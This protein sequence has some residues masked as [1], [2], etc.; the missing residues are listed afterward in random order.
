MKI[1]FFLF[2]SSYHV[3]TLLQC[4]LYTFIQ[5]TMTTVSD[6]SY[7]LSYPFTRH[8]NLP[9]IH[10]FLCLPLSHNNVNTNI[11]RSKVAGIKNTYGMPRSLSIPT[12]CSTPHTYLLQPESQLLELAAY[13]LQ[14]YLRCSPLLPHSPCLNMGPHLGT[15]TLHLVLVFQPK[16]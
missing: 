11:A 1:Y 13:I 4:I 12:F 7:I 6:H 2:L 15:P 8:N 3:Y 10:I 9:H 14:H 16:V 5:S